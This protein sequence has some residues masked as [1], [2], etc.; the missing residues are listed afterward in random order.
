MASRY[1]P[2]PAS[3]HDLIGTLRSR[4]WSSTSCS[5]TSPFINQRVMGAGHVEN[6]VDLACRTA[7]GY[8]G[9]AHITFPTRS[10]GAGAYE[11]SSVRSATFRITLPTFARAGAPIARAL[12]APTCR[13]DSECRARRWRFWQA[14]AHCGRETELEAVAEKLGAPIVKALLGKAAVAGR[15][16]LHD[17]RHRSA[18]NEAFTGG[19]RRMRHAA[20]RRAAH[21]PTSNSCRSPGKHGAFRWTRIRAA[22]ASAIR[23]KSD[24]SA[25]AGGTLEDCFRC[26]NGTKTGDFLRKPRTGMEEWR[27]CWKNAARAAICR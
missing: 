14:G 21:F 25:T 5:W 1:S 27:S 16:S 6:I 10:S 22:S 13:G 11:Q 18:G 19:A 12:R 7:L 23:S 17:R 2:L 24:S 20:D 9:V 15:Q 3:F 26:C 8:R 4:M